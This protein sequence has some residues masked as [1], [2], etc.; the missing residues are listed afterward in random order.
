MDPIEQ[1]LDRWVAA[2]L[3]SAEQAR[4]LQRFEAG[5][6]S[7]AGGLA[8]PSARVEDPA[9]APGDPSATAPTPAT[10]AA[11]A[12][13]AAP[14][15]AVDRTDRRSQVAEAVGYVG[16]ALAIG[17]LALLLSELWDGL[18]LGGRLALA[19]VVAALLGGA[20]WVLRRRAEPALARLTSALGTG[21]V[22]AA[23]W[24]SSVVVRDAL[25]RSWDDT[26]LAV[27]GVVAVVALAMYV[28]RRR[29][30]PQITAYVGIALVVAALL[31]RAPLSLANTWWGVV[32]WALGV[33]WVLLGA[34][35]WVRPGRVAELLG[36]LAALFALLVSAFGS[37]RSGLLMLATVTA[38][39]FVAVAVLRD[40]TSALI[41]G[42]TGLFVFVPQLTFELFG[43]RIGAPATLLMVGL[44]LVVLAVGIARIK[45]AVDEP[46]PAAAQTRTD[47]DTD[48]HREVRS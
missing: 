41:V 37:E 28:P 35:G 17:A 5:S 16:A 27:A 40:R 31:D 18:L 47:T 13:A 21:T 19:G 12:L 33:A 1:Q 14:A 26:A 43:D 9:P 32:F 38:A 2:G 44:L 29:G 22:A 42:A 48:T 24:L 7:G 11:P 3:I 23:G 20:W 15:T 8:Q 39:A 4:A 36:G 34:G 25:D 46:G 30:L 45:R 10:A 6:A